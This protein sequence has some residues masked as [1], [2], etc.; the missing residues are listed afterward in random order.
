MSKLYMEKFLKY[1]IGVMFL[2]TTGLSEVGPESQD[3]LYGFPRL[4]GKIEQ[5]ILFLT[6]GAFVTLN[7]MLFDILGSRPLR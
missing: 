2:K 7:H 3:I 1:P 4:E 6:R 5:T